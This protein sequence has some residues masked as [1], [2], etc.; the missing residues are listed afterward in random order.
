M[1][2]WSDLAAHPIDGDDRAEHVREYQPAV[3]RDR[4]K[5]LVTSECLRPVRPAVDAD[6]GPST[7]PVPASMTSASDPNYGDDE[8]LELDVLPIRLTGRNGTAVS[9]RVVVEAKRIPTGPW[10]GRPHRDR[11]RRHSVTGDSVISAARRG[12]GTPD[13][14]AVRSLR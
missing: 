10:T 7:G 9:Q 3:G 8:V 2:Q 14:G 13:A 5:G 6:P 1:R 4:V 12:A 11:G